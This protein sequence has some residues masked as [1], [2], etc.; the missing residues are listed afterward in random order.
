MKKTA[1]LTL[2]ISSLFILFSCQD[3]IYEA[4]REDVKPEDATVSG[5]IGSI[6]RYTAGG[7]E[8]LVLAADNGL[9]YKQKDNSSHGA[10]NTYPIP[11]TLHSYSFDTSSHTGEQILS[12]LAN[13]T[14]LYMIS[15]E[16]VHTTTEGYSYPSNIKLWGKNITATGNT[17]DSAGEWT[18]IT[19]N[20]TTLFPVALNSDKSYYISNFIAF[21]TNAPMAAHRAAFIRTYNSTEKAYQYYKLEGLNAPSE[22][23]VTA[24][25]IIDAEPS[26][27]SSYVPAARSAAYFKGEVKFFTSQVATTNET[28]DNDA[29]YY[30]YSNGGNNLYFN[31]GSGP[32]KISADSDYTIASLATTADSILIGYG[33]TSTGYGGGIGRS[34]LVDGKPTGVVGF[35]S[36]AKFQITTSYM[37]PVVLNA[38]P[39][40]TEKESSLYA[41]VTFAGSSYN[42]DNIGLWSYYP[43]RGNWN[44]E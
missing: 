39:E 44:R 37:V 15:A 42:F 13:S 41:A 25:S 20:N 11:F 14:T 1:L 43:S 29:T 32:N 36:N 3:P 7:T 35:D 18:P 28:Y 33:T 12:V 2:I 31:N 19:Q 21:Q 40:K 6:T 9:R 22:I 10:W 17:L 16:Y 5:N 38:S 34:L 8:F 24:A 27:D 30:Y 26:S 23:T 4:I